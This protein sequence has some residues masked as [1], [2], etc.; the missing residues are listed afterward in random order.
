MCHYGYCFDPAVCSPVFFRPY[1]QLEVC[2]Y[3][4]L[5]RSALEGGTRL[6]EDDTDDSEAEADEMDEVAPTTKE[7]AAQ[8]ALEMERDS[9]GEEGSDSSSS[10]NSDSDSGKGSDSDSP[11]NELGKGAES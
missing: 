2:A 10:R 5:E 9:Y 8:W 7:G 4:G 6:I 1:R 11:E 3:C